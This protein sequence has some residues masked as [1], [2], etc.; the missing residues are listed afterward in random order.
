MKE[1]NT[2]RFSGLLF[3]GK[4]IRRE[5]MCCRSSSRANSEKQVVK[6][7]L[8]HESDRRVSFLAE[9]RSGTKSTSVEIIASRRALLHRNNA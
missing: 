2:V 6:E 8:V 4:N 1:Q 5:R 9:T 7:T 3:R